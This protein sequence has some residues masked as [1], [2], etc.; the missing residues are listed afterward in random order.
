LLKTSKK[1][2]L[3]IWSRQAIIPVFL[4]GLTVFVHNGKIF[5]KLRITREKAGFKFGVFI[6]T[7][8]K[9]VTKKLK[10]KKK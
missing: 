1:K 9:C 2:N 5:K 6:K 7:R 4:I 3:Y 10:T 8:T